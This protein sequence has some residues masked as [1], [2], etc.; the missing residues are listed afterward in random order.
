MREYVLVALLDTLVDKRVSLVD[1]LVD[2]LLDTLKKKRESSLDESEKEIVEKLLM[3]KEIVKQIVKEIVKEHEERTRKSIRQPDFFGQTALLE[4]VRRGHCE[5]VRYLLDKGSRPLFER[6]S[7]GKTALYYS[8][9]IADKQAAIQM[10]E[11]LL[12][13]YTSREERLLLL[14]ASA[15]GMG[16]AE[17]SAESSP[18]LH[19]F[20]M[21]Q[22]ELAAGSSSDLL[23][24]A[25]KLGYEALAWEFIDRGAN[26]SQID[27]LADR[28]LS[29]VE[30]ERFN[31]FLTALKLGGVHV[32]NVIEGDP[33]QP[34][35]HDSVG[36]R[37]FAEGLAALFLN[38]YVKS[39]VTVGISG[40]W[41]IGKSSLMLQTEMILIQAAAQQAFP[42]ILPIEDFPQ[43][44]KLT[45]KD[46]KKYNKVRDGVKALLAAT[47]TD[48]IVG[49]PLVYFLDNY[50]D[51]YHQVYKSLALME[52]GEMDKTLDSSANLHKIPN[53]LTVRYNAWHYR[54]E[55]EAWA[56][57][58]VTITK[59][60]EE[61]MTESQRIRSRWRY[62]KNERGG[63]ILLQ[64][65]LPCILALFLS[66]L[67]TWTVWMLLRRSKHSDLEG[68]KYGSIAITLVV[69]FWTVMRQ[70]LSVFK[71]VTVQV[72]KYIHLPDHSTNLGYQHQV[73]S[74]IKFLKE[75]ICEK[76]SLLWKFLAGN[77]LWG[78]TV[79]GTSIPKSHPPSKNDLRMI[80]FVDD[81]DRCEDTVILK[82]LS[83]VNLVLAV[84][85][86]N[87][88]LGMD[89]KMISRAIA[90]NYQNQY[91]DDNNSNEVDADNLAEKYLRKIIQ[92]TLALPDLGND[93]RKEFLNQQLGE[94]IKEI[95]ND[96]TEGSS[97]PSPGAQLND[98][99]NLHFLVDA[100]GQFSD[101]ENLPQNYPQTGPD[102]LVDVQP[103][104]VENPHENLL[105]N[106]PQSVPGSLSDAQPSDV[107][108]PLQNRPQSGL[109]KRTVIFKLLNCFRALRSRL[110]GW[111][112]SDRDMRR[113]KLKSTIVNSRSW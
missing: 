109:E 101:Q 105:Q 12:N 82:V 26:T 69:I 43:Q 56:G 75:Q 33:D 113:S 32:K 106:H 65:L 93:E 29:D 48:N 5:A 111:N 79:K 23:F 25:I 102:S 94:E 86:I 81:L 58:A 42:N 71:P 16:T 98:P 3:D 10:A 95:G 64:F 17:Q 59:A 87:V 85:D 38:P 41:G 8:V 107:K 67:A 78:D 1:S 22:R 60:M 91:Q 100:D 45:R 77:W 55:L 57:L 27:N 84:C 30:R 51:K 19:N 31:K 15:I 73:I 62:T 37:V 74:D 110:Y 24:S 68:L 7:E 50:Q 112:K 76:P 52:R 108:Y 66:G 4:A 40:E 47:R 104:D 6:N 92:L 11:I 96:V 72:M 103:S 54:N 13:H 46:R 21:Q 99:E 80:V 39:P 20:L 63:E 34:T 49:D 36:R 97:R 83:A 14:W 88:I 28:D 70:L 2:T 53:V 35:I 61:S 9:H 44:F 18:E 89:K 90:N